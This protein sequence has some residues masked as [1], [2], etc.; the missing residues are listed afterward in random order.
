[1]ASGSG[2]DY[3]SFNQPPHDYFARTPTDR[4]AQLRSRLETATASLA[5]DTEVR[6]LTGL[7]ELLEIPVTSQMLVFSTTS[8]QLSRITPSNPRALYFNDEVYLGYIPGGKIEV[9][10]LDRDLGAV[11][12]IFDIP[13]GAHPSPIQVERATRC[14][15][16]HAGDDTGHVP[17]L[18]VKSVVSGPNGGSLDAFRLERTGH[19]VPLEERFGGWYL[20]GH[21]NWT[22]HW[23]NAMGRFSDGEL[24]RIVNPAEDKVAW[25]RYPRRTSDLLPQLLHEHQAGFVNRVV[26]AAY[27][28]RTALHVGGGVLTP[29]T[30]A[31]L[32]NQAD[33]VVRYLLF[34]DEV[35]LPPG[36]VTGDGAYIADFRRARR[37]VGGRSLKDLDLRQRLLRYRCS[38]MIYSPVFEGLP[39]EMKTRV[40]R[41]LA[42]AL[43]PGKEDPLG[44]HLPDDEKGVIR[45]ILRATLKDLPGSW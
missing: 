42:Q 10:A 41:R 28:A 21:G 22:N 40:Y 20:T 19:D 17:G 24:V 39:E 6:F 30:S 37:E 14:M 34:V 9:L 2:P 25:D 23:G 44:R 31:E 18:V 38:Y 15:N 16:C 35:L 12:Y 43:Q 45:E 11:F 5:A 29:E 4:F 8:L 7:L 32:E 26:E 36:G 13:R 33:R 3:R 1:M 27:R